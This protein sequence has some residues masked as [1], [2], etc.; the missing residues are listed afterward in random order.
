[1]EQFL[2]KLSLAQGR[3]LCLSINFSLLERGAGVLSPPDAGE[4]HVAVLAARAVV[5]VAVHAR[6]VVEE[7]G[8]GLRLHQ[9]VAAVVERVVEAVVVRRA[10]RAIEA[11]LVPRRVAEVPA[12]AVAVEAHRAALEERAAR[13]GARDWLE[14]PAR[15]V[16]VQRADHAEVAGA[17]EA[18]LA[19]AV[20]DRVA[21]RRAPAVD[22][23]RQGR[24]RQRAAGAVEVR[25]TH[26]ALR[27]DTA[28]NIFWRRK[29]ECVCLFLQYL[30]Q[31]CARGGRR[32]LKDMCYEIRRAEACVD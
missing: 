6:A 29:E 15:A 9:R 32:I 30:I 4:V 20:R 2:I 14:H 8:A 25:R 13:R 26:R 19:R 22:G 1:M 7:A 17:V 23:T 21:P 27:V 10:Q 18:R 16:G 12:R 11:L 28:N 24:L 5:V 31:S 3:A